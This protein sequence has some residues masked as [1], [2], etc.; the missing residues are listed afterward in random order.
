MAIPDLCPH[1]DHPMSVSDDGSL[2]TCSACGQ[3]LSRRKPTKAPPAPVVAPVVA[4]AEPSSRSSWPLVLPAVGLVWILLMVVTPLAAGRATLLLT[5]ALALINAGVALT[6]LLRKRTVP[7]LPTATLAALLGV[8]NYQVY[9]ALGPDHFTFSRPPGLLDWLQYT[10]VHVIRAADLLDFLEEF[11]W[12]LHTVRNRSVLAGCILVVLH[13]VVNMLILGLLAGWLVRARRAAT[14]AGDPDATAIR[15]LRQVALL[16]CLIAYAACS[17]LQ[18]W[19]FTDYVLWPVENLV[20][21]LDAPDLF[22]IF[23]WHWHQVPPSFWNSTLAIAYRLAVGVVVAEGLSR[24][25]LTVFGGMGLTQHQ[26]L[27]SLESQDVETRASACAALHRL[28]DEVLPPLLATLARDE[29]R[30]GACEALACFGAT[31][32]PHLVPLL[33]DAD[34][35]LR[36]AAVETLARIGPAAALALEPLRALRHDRSP[37]VRSALAGGLARIGDSTVVPVLLR[38]LSDEAPTVRGAAAAALAGNRVR[39]EQA[40]SALLDALRDD[41]SDVREAAVRSLGV[42]AATDDGAA[43]LLGRAL[44]DRS[45]TV[46]RAAL[47]ALCGLGSRASPALPALLKHLDASPFHRRIGARALGQMGAAACSAASALEHLLA[48]HD[49][50]VR[51]EATRALGRLGSAALPALTG[52]LSHRDPVVRREAVETLGRMGPEARPALSALQRLARDPDLQQ[53]VMRA[54]LRI[55]GRGGE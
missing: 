30:T 29:S 46:H 21:T 5:V 13:L 24:L 40:P 4:I 17:V 18:G 35:V 50:Q 31:A 38:L 33:S 51:T 23:N 41:S 26:L 45:P 1:C 39:G 32:V 37:E 2:R 22:Q 43:A 28:G 53:E 48:D 8:L 49:E 44:A 36:R 52:A 25:H 12:N 54:V 27:Q 10:A 14:L 15:Q 9:V 19:S 47:L 11:G 34:A 6:N 42:F 7:T 16:I 20:R 3:P 55:A